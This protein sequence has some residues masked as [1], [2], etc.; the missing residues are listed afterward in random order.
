MGFFPSDDQPGQFEFFIPDGS[1]LGTYTTLYKP[2]YLR[3][4]DPGLEAGDSVQDYVSLALDTRGSI[5]DLGMLRLENADYTTAFV[6]SL[7]D[8]QIREIV[9]AESFNDLEMVTNAN[10][11]VRNGTQESFEGEVQESGP[12]GGTESSPT[13]GTVL[14]DPHCKFCFHYSSE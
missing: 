1:N 3:Y 12:T 5:Y 4:L 2:E 14:G 8:T 6:N 10:V 9:Q 7:S 13:G 11:V